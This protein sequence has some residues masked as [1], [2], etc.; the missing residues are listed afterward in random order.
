MTLTTQTRT[1]ASEPTPAR[2]ETAGHQ[3]PEK[4]SGL[5]LSPAQVSGSVLAAVSAAVASSWLGVAG[6][7]IGAALFSLF[8]T[9]GSALYAQT[10]R[11]S[12]S[13]VRA[14]RPTTSVGR[15][16]KGTSEPTERTTAGERSEP[17]DGMG[18]GER[19]RAL[20]WRRV[21][22][23][24]G[25]VLVI[26]LGAITAFEKVSGTSVSGLTG[27]DDQQ[28]TSI[29]RILGKSAPEATDDVA[30]KDTSGQ[31]ADESG[32][33]SEVDETS[34]TTGPDHL[35]DSAT[36]V[37]TT[38]E[39]ADPTPTEEDGGETEND[40]DTGTEPGTDT[41]TESGTDPD[42]SAS[43]SVGGSTAP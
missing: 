3:Q 18:L 13:A 2:P 30:V 23:A 24:T 25:L 31:V 6:T 41:G 21:L 12:H 32:A 17:A 42:E 10:L 9:V 33:E 15:V 4:S 34:E 11:H 14:L 35:S 36:D 37:P 19:L 28:G 1:P 43:S 29:S 38:T 8:G 39:D 7:I 22:A 5:G 20:P 27:G 40:T 16:T 26:A